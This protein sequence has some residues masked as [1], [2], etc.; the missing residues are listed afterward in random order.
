MAGS[1]RGVWASERM[2]MQVREWDVH[3]A[4]KCAGA[5]ASNLPT[6]ILCTKRNKYVYMM[7]F[8]HSNMRQKIW[9]QWRLMFE[10]ALAFILFQRSTVHMPVTNSILNVG[11]CHHKKNHLG[12]WL[13]RFV[14]FKAIKFGAPG[15][16]K[17][18]L[19]TQRSSS[20]T[21]ILLKHVETKFCDLS[22][23]AVH[24]V[25]LHY[26]LLFHLF[27]PCIFS[28]HDLPS[29]GNMDSTWTTSAIW[30]LGNPATNLRKGPDLVCP[31][32][33]QVQPAMRATLS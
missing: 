17:V 31:W 19:T 24:E 8:C 15:L 22:I 4:F 10:G 3:V 1:W 2:Y 29:Q 32:W 5:H 16:A 23:Y 13:G 11:V 18:L 33:C 28:L 30:V 9:I 21:M 6:S 12:K 14:D 26:P 27:H 20:E 7:P 25:T